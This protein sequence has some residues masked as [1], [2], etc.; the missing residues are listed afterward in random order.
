MKRRTLLAGGA[1]AALG[2]AAC[3]GRVATPLADDIAER[4][5]PPLGQIITA[6][7]L[8][9]HALEAGRGG[10]PVILIHGASVNLR[11]WSFSLM[12]PL[13]RKRRVIAMDR[14]GFGYSKR[15]SGAWPPAKQAAQ[16]RQAALQMGVEKPIV[17]GHSWGASV[18]LAWALDFPQ[19]I[20]GVVSVSGATMPWGIGA[21]LFGAL[22]VGRVGVDYYQASLSRRAEDGAI[23]DFVSRAFRPQIPPPGYIDYV[24]APLSLRAGTLEANGDDLT[25]LHPALVGMAK[26]YP[27]MSV[28][29]EIVHGERDWLLSVEQHVEG[30]RALVPGARASIARNVGHMAHHARPD[31]L[32]SAIDRLAGTV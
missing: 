8:P 27:Q 24:G 19:D 4:E 18:A 13:A 29:V 30:F 15:D 22:G 21:S 17:V 14:P 3:S 20:T 6:N 10:P 31:L 28:P 9:V 1:L 23:E 5:F 26:R 16:L 7:G 25:S 2:V 32:D 11:D 12:E